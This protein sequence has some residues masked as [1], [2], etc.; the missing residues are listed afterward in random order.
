MRGTARFYLHVVRLLAAERVGADTVDLAGLRAG[1]ITSFTARTRATRGLSSARQ[2]VSALRTF[3]RFLV[4]RTGP[5]INWD[6]GV[7]VRR[8]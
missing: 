5:R 2:V 8:A 4:I 6:A 3:L 1:D 7:A